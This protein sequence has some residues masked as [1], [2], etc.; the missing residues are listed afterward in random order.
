MTKKIFRHRSKN[1]DHHQKK[2]RASKK[3]FITT[4]NFYH[5]RKKF[6]SS[7]KKILKLKK[8]FVIA[9]KFLS[10]SK[11]F[12]SLSKKI[13]EFEKNFCRRKKIHR[14]KKIFTRRRKNFLET[15]VPPRGGG[16]P[17][18]GPKLGS[19]WNPTTTPHQ[20]HQTRPWLV[21]S[22]MIKIFFDL[23]QKFFFDFD[24]IFFSTTP[25]WLD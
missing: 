22:T 24:K 17:P 7:S 5:R 13:F 6:W 23:D 10:S 12:W 20:L 2:F 15:R 3:I 18:P 11:K 16:R 8:I 21:T 9:K 4:K 19:Q 1:F 25:F 14:R